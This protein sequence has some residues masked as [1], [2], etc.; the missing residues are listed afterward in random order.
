MDEFFKK[1]KIDIFH[2]DFKSKS[3]NFDFTLL[4]PHTDF[5][6][7]KIVTFDHKV[8]VTQKTHSIRTSK[9][10]LLTNILITQKSRTDSDANVKQVRTVQHNETKS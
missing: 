2:A 6:Y 5:C 9:H 10:T 4:I 3:Y 7:S 1:R 8:V